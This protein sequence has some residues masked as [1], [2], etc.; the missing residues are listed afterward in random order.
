MT[1]CY[2]FSVVAARHIV[3]IVIS[4]DADVMTPIALPHH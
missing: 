4:C 1:T 2:S 3:A